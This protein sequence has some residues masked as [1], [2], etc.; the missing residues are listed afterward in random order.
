MLFNLLTVYLKSIID[1]TIA[2][3]NGILVQ[4]NGF[5]IKVYI[6]R[7]HIVVNVIKKKHLGSKAK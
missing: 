5:R 6:F 1:G 2:W 3:T 7:Y 4:A